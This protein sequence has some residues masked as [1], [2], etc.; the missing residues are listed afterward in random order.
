MRISCMIL[1]LT[2]LSG[3]SLLSKQQYEQIDEATPPSVK[4]TKKD[5]KLCLFDI[6]PSSFTHNCDLF[7]WLQ[8]WIDADKTPWSERKVVLAQLGQSEH[9]RIIAFLLSLPSDTPY[10]DRLRAQLG[11]QELL[12]ELTPDVASIVNVV[13]MKPNK[14]RMELESAMSVLRKENAHRKEALQQLRTELEIQ[15]QKLDELLQIE[16][17]LMDKNRSN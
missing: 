4:E 13:A 6:A 12:P 9:D 5:D 14:Q 16:A 15:Q 11:M 10:Q 8:V 3:C 17:T 1:T 7:Y 2:L